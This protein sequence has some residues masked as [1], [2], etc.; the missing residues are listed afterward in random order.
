MKEQMLRCV[1]GVQTKIKEVIQPT[2]ILT[3]KTDGGEAYVDTGVKVIIALIVGG[4]LLGGFVLL[5]KTTM[6]PTLTTK[7]TTMFATPIV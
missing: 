7:I 4:L 6:L 2:E 3:L 5:T 1:V